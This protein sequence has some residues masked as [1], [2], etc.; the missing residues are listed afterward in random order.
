MLAVA[1]E[2]GGQS[3]KG[4]DPVDG[5]VVRGLQESDQLRESVEAPGYFVRKGVLGGSLHQAFINLRQVGAHHFGVGLGG[6]ARSDPA[7]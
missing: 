6:P 2:E 4:E 5:V 3:L 1:D 7:L